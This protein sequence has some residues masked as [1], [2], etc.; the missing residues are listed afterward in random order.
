MKHKTSKL[1]SI[2]L[3]LV[4]VLGLAPAMSISAQA[5]ENT[6]VKAIQL[7]DH[8]GETPVA[9][10]IEGGKGGSTE[11]GIW[12]GNYPQ[13]E[14]ADVTG[15]TE[16][17]DYISANSKEFSIDPIKWRVLKNADGKLFL[18]SDV[19]LDLQPFH[20][21]SSHRTWWSC[22]LRTWLN[23]IGPFRFLGSAFIAEER[24]AIADTIT[25]S[26]NMFGEKVFLLSV[27]EATTEDYGFA[28]DPDATD[29][30]SGR[31]SDELTD[32]VSDLY[33]SMSYTG[34]HTWWLRTSGRYGNLALYVNA[35][36]H[37]SKYG[38][39]VN[40][41]YTAVRP[42]LNIDLNS[43]LFTSAAAGGKNGTVGKLSA[44]DKNT[45]NEWKLT[46]LDEDRQLAV[47]DDEVSGTPGGTVT[48]NY[49][50]ATVKTD[51]APNE[52]IS[53]ILTDKN[54]NLLYYGRLT[55]PDETDGEVDVKIPVALAEGTYTLKLFSEQYNGDYKTDYASEFDDVTLNVEV[56]T[57]TFD[58]NGGSVTPTSD[59]TGEDG[60]LEKL[61]IPTRI[62]SYSF[63]GWYTELNGG[64]KVDTSYI[65]EK[66]TTIYAHWKN[67]GGSG[68]SV[69]TK[70]TL[71]YNTN[72]GNTITATRH[73][74]NATVNLTVTPTREGYDFTGWY[75]DKELKN[76][77]TSVKMDGNKTVYAGW[78]AAGAEV[79]TPVEEIP[80][81]VVTIN[82]TAYLLNGKPMT[83][84]SAPF[85][86]GNNRI[87]LPVRVIANALDITNDNIKWDSATKTAYFTREDGK[88]VSCTVNSNV[89]QIGD[90]KVTIDTAPVIRNSRIYLPM[91]AL[92]NAFDVPDENILWD[93]VARTVTVTKKD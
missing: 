43:V 24:A 30:E 63:E 16:D 91:R 3:A 60:R 4:M 79:D 49:T 80:L 35:D 15:L 92:F 73:D 40:R 89:I 38:G 58:P 28:T 74:K 25:T 69:I 34:D 54:D 84:D 56:T 87:M 57:V 39:S 65:F 88:I 50:G 62:G 67:T 83:M 36:G 6:D 85:I 32:Y 78:K 17:V 18:L 7:V 14:L 45:T 9:T 26:E 68:G 29:D 41:A 75:A 72:G 46:L 1:W 10:Y 2:F 12:F 82:S 33:T 86:D 48:L 20:E 19:C 64:E 5:A 44:I 31:V 21:N 90:E 70:Y 55:Q 61:P 77:V 23:D 47:T 53:A 52:Y 59:T 22:T 13:N 8:S 76:A 42:A 66:D 71:T 93:A 11:G 27:D 37:V 51:E 81:L